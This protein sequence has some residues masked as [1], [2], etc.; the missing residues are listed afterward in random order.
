MNTIA[1]TNK[2]TYFLVIVIFLVR[3]STPAFSLSA[4]SK[5]K[6]TTAKTCAPTSAELQKC[7]SLEEML[8]TVATRLP[9]GTAQ[10]ETTL[11]S[12]TLLVRA[13]KQVVG[14]KNHEEFATKEPTSNRLLQKCSSE[15]LET[16]VHALITNGSWKESSVVLESAVEATKAVAILTRLWSDIDFGR[17]CLPLWEEWR[18]LAPEVAKELLPHQ[19][20]G[21]KWAMDCFQLLG[22][23]TMLPPDIQKAH[24]TMDLPFCI[25]PGAMIDTPN[26]TLPNLLEQVEFKVDIIR[27]TSEKVVPERRETAWEGDETVAPFEYSGKSM[28]RKAWSPLVRQIRDSL[29]AQTGTYY[30]GCLLNHYPDGGSGMRYHIDPDQGMLW[31]YSTAVV[32]VGATRKFAFREIGKASS[33]PHVFTL[34]HGDCTEMFGDCQARF[35]HTVRT[36]EMPNEKSAR[37]SLV[38]KKTLGS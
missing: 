29:A 17:V 27:T 30:D 15:P 13:S 38:F 16:A 4:P 28:P 21:L 33:K 9:T 19:L 5:K 26:L 8:Q 11:L 32:S 6:T 7:G 37:A 2:T 36:A 25:R 14:I 24:D 23:D 31:D 3:W 18:R 20:S 22:L 1:S 35:Q 10:E 34:M 12:S